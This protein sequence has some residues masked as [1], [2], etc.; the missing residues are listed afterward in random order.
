MLSCN[1]SIGFDPRTLPKTHGQNSFHLNKYQKQHIPM[2]E[3]EID[4]K[5]NNQK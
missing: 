1:S 2:I 3:F 4:S 5:T